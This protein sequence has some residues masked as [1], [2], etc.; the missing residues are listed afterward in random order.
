M[1]DDLYIIVC[2][3]VCLINI[4]MIKLATL[5]FGKLQI[6]KFNK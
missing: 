2:M 5:L 3:L 6:G 4:L 1:L